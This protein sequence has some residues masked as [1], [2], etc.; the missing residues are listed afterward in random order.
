[1]RA[2]RDIEQGDEITFDYEEN[3]TKAVQLL[4]TPQH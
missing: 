3:M 4:N 2:L 1:M